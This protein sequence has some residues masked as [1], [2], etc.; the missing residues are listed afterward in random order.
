LFASEFLAAQAS[1]ATT[2]SPKGPSNDISSLIRRYK[3]SRGKGHKK[4]GFLDLAEKSRKDYT[5]YLAL[6][7]SEF[8][9]MPLAA[10]E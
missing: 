6:I 4:R 7:E 5:R 8:G 9:S 2:A 10:V 1:R 3:K